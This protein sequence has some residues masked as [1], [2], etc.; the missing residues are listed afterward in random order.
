MARLGESSDARE[1]GD[2]EVKG[3]G[4]AAVGRHAVELE[5]CGRY[6]FGRACKKGG[7]YGEGRDLQST[8]HPQFPAGRRQSGEVVSFLELL[9]RWRCNFL[10]TKA[11]ASLKLSLIF[12]ATFSPTGASA[13]SPSLSEAW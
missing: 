11:I 9:R 4:S 5:D 2:P 3:N 1:K 10:T 6:G 12:P 8:R 13:A 7:M